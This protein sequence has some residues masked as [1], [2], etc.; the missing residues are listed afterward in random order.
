MEE[1]ASGEIGVVQ[2]HEELDVY[3]LAFTAAMR[4]FGVSKGF[5]REE[6]YSL[7]DQIRRSSRSVCS[8]IAEAWRKRRYEGTFVDKLN[9]AESGAA[10]TQTWLRFAMDCGYLAQEGGQKLHQTYDF[11]I[12]ELDNMIINP[13]NWMSR[14]VA[15][16]FSSQEAEV[17]RQ[18]SEVRRQRT[19]DSSPT[20][21][22]RSHNGKGTSQGFSRFDCLAK[23]TSIC[24]ILVSFYREF[25]L[26]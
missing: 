2:S 13:S 25:S 21:V 6:M 16:D 12:T 4:I 15:N 3:Q 9:D 19:E 14:E 7:T 26:K 24:I 10:E 5:P 1:R 18:K 22:D 23:G 17:R 11:I 8:N 20:T